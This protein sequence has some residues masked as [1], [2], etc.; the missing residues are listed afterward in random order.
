MLDTP[1]LA[2]RI[3]VPDLHPVLAG[4]ALPG[5]WTFDSGVAGPHV[6]VV[7]LVHGNEFAGAVVLRRWL[8]DGLRPSRGRLTL[9]FAN[10]AA[11]ARFDP[12]DPTLSRYVDEDLNRVW[13][14]EWLDGPRDSAEIRRARELRPV[15]ESAD[16]LIDL[17]SMLWPSD[18]LVLCGRTSRARALALSL[19]GPEIVVAEDAHPEGGRLL[20]HADFAAEDGH[21]TALLVEG[22]QHWESGTVEVLEAAVASILRHAGLIPP[23]PARKVAKSLWR[24][25]QGI[26][27]ATRDFTFVTPVRGGQVVPAAGTLIARDGAADIRTP[28]DDCMLVMPTPRI[29]RGHLAVRLARQAG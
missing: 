25:T 16:I 6:V 1:S 24:V 2:V 26:V 4:N 20:D 11:F 3:P 22:G 5:V 21:R 9:V 17:H 14:P 8:L 13:R 27:A 7:S 23:R 10:L 15:V 28:H 18:P 12:A 29:M 19:A